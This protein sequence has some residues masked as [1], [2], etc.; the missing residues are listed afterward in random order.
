MII[1][2][3]GIADP[4]VALGWSSIMAVQLFSSGM[5]MLILG[6]FGEYIGRIFICINDAPQYV[7]RETINI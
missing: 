7:I 6:M 4:G 5:I 1:E 2:R 3:F